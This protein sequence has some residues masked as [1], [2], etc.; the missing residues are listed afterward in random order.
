M[1]SIPEVRFHR[2]LQI[3]LLAINLVGI[4]VLIGNILRGALHE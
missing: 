2:R 1:T 3:W 4:A